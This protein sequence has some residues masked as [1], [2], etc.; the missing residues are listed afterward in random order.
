MDGRIS[1]LASVAEGKSP[2][3]R[4]CLGTEYSGL[5]TEYSGCADDPRLGERHLTWAS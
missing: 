4:L 1:T 3:A 2:D 5:G